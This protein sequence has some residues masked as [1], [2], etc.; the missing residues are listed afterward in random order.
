MSNLLIPLRT[1]NK[2]LKQWRVFPLRNSVSSSMKRNWMTIALSDTNIL[3]NSNLRLVLRGGAPI[4]ILV[5]THFSGEIISIRVEPDNTIGILKQRLTDRVNVPPAIQCLIFS[6]RVM[7][8]DSETMGFYNLTNQSLI[9]LH[10]NVSDGSLTQVFVKT[11]SGKSLSLHI[12]LSD[13]V[14]SMKEMIQTWEN[15]P[16]EQQVLYFSGKALIDDWLLRDCN[17][18]KD[19]TIHVSLRLR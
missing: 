8:D 13:T 3:Q 2:E 18:Q 7:T 19:S 15:I 1:S 6:G 12:Y 11:L 16:S 17:I 5:K 4:Q 10:L 9:N 14:A